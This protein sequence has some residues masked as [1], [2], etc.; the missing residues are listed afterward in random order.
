MYTAFA[1]MELQPYS[2]M[3]V[4]ARLQFMKLFPGTYYWEGNP[5]DPRRMDEILVHG[6]SRTKWDDNLIDVKFTM[7]WI[8]KVYGEE[9]YVT[10]TYYFPLDKRLSII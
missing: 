8:D 6:F 5:E 2:E 7:D 1:D 10:H 4:W 3:P 9:M